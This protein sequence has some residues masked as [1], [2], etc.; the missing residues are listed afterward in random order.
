MF[1]IKKQH[2]FL[3]LFLFEQLLNRNDSYKSIP[4]DFLQISKYILPPVDE[5]FGTGTKS[6]KY[7]YP[8]SKSYERAM[9]MVHNLG[10]M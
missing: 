5:Q 4:H 10:L 1:L 2:L 7:F 6:N 3:Y 9:I 8:I